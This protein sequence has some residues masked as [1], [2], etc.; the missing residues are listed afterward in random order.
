[1]QRWGLGV[2]AIT[3]LP[4][5]GS[6]PMYS[7][8]SRS[9]RG[10]RP[11]AAVTESPRRPWLQSWRRGD[12]GADPVRVLPA[13]CRRGQCRQ[14]RGCDVAVRGQVP[15]L[16]RSCCRRPPWSRRRGGRVPE[17]RDLG[18]VKRGA[19]RSFLRPKG[20]LSQRGVQS[21]KPGERWEL[22]HGKGLTGASGGWLSDAG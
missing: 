6:S 11:C 10:Q 14:G 1:M 17:R 20:G 5:E 13:R 2:P 8:S 18:S 16:A 19:L 7:A 3:Y 9:R 15:G 21:G 22:C 4:E 12:G